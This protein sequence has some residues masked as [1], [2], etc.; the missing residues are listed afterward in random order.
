[1]N[2]ISSPTQFW[3]SVGSFETSQ[4]LSEFDLRTM[5]WMTCTF[6][7]F[8]LVLA[9]CAMKGVDW[10]QGCSR[11]GSMA[12]TVEYGTGTRTEKKAGI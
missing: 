3:L 8:S 7:M 11:T 6:A 2:K 4:T 10:E 1:M 5:I 9:F 12:G